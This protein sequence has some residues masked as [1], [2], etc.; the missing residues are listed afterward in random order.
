MY[1]SKWTLAGARHRAKE[2]HVRR[3]MANGI[4]RKE[5]GPKF[6]RA[7]APAAPPRSTCQHAPR[8]FK[9]IERQMCGKWGETDHQEAVPNPLS[10]HLAFIFPE[11]PG[12]DKS[13]AIILC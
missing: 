4:E 1:A 7:A 5:N 6:T 9:E 3:T 10:A 13:G 11:Y 8:K 12:G 2:S